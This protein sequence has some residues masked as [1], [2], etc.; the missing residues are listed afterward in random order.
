MATNFPTSLDNSTSLPYPTSTSDTNSPSLA[1]GQDNQNDAVI[2]AQTKLGIGSSVAASNQVL[3]GTGA[4]QSN[5][6]LLTSAN[7][8]LATGSGAFVFGTSPTITSPTLTTPVINNPTLNTDSVIGYTSANT[9][10]VYGLSVTS[11]KI[12]GTAISNNT[13]PNG[14]LDAN[15]VYSG[16]LG[17]SSSYTGGVTSFSTGG[18]TGYYINLGGIKMFWGTSGVQNLSGAA[19]QSA[20]FTV[21]MPTSFFSTIQ[22][23]TV[24]PSGTPGGTSAVYAGSTTAPTTTSWVIEFGSVAGSGG[25][26]L[27]FSWIVIGT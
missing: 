8:T 23:A 11:S 21:N 24:S 15:A 2:A 3:T 10:T 5:W 20:S 4:G 17:L 14:P 25:S 27:Y 16:N 1:G 6:Q 9:G 22:S 26:N 18:G 12:S 13:I 7:V 19:P